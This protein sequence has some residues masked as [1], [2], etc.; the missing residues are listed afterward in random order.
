VALWL[1]A[2]VSLGLLLIRWSRLLGFS[3]CNGSRVSTAHG[4]IR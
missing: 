2:L 4:S 1:L 3:G